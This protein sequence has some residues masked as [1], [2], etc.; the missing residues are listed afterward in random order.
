MK[1]IKECIKIWEQCPAH[2]RYI[3]LSH[4]INLGNRTE[5]PGTL[6]VPE[7]YSLVV[8]PCGG[9]P[10]F[11]SFSFKCFYEVN[12]VHIFSMHLAGGSPLDTYSPLQRAEVLPSNFHR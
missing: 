2:L 11:L 6:E 1:N 10:F 9:T 12:H 3:N 8:P 4:T 7:G 5:C